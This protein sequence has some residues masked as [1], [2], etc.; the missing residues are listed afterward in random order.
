MEVIECKHNV[1]CELGACGNKAT[2][3][4]KF[5]RVGL[6]SRIYACD[7]C[8]AELSVAI[9]KVLPPPK[10]VETARRKTKA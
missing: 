1:R 3:A 9:A 8:L 7:K 5:D 4:V 2:H 10:S 6:R